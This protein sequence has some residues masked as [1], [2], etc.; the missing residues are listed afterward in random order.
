VVGARRPQSRSAE[1]ERL[2]DLR[3]VSVQRLSGL[4]ASASRQLL[5]RPSSRAR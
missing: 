1:V 5:L 2:P 3:R 4:A